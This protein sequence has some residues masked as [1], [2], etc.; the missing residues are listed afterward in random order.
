[1]S[2]RLRSLAK[3][4]AA[5]GFTLLELLVAISLMAVLAVLGWR[6]LDSVLASRERISQAS[7]EVRALSVTFTQMDEDLRRSWPVRLL[8]LP[9][10]PVAFVAEGANEQPALVLVRELP[11]GSGGSQLQRVSYRLRD[12]VLERGFLSLLLPAQGGGSG[13]GMA[14]GSGASAGTSAEAQFT[15]QP[16]MSGVRGLQ[17][18]G[19][20]TGQGWVPAAA[21]TS[22]TGATA[23]AT[24][25]VTGVEVSIEWR[26]GERVVRIFPV[27]D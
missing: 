2:A 8:N 15:W 25:M 3:R 5:A 9:Q 1:V 6:G 14:D 13:G 4:R 22:R 16:L 19:W 10:P 12:G 27:K 26:E 20:I 7:D 23:A 18:R 11:P 17:M 24:G 21:L